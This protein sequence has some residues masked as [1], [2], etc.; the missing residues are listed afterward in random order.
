MKTI[1]KLKQKLKIKVSVNLAKK[2]EVKVE[3]FI[4]PIIDFA[5]FFLRSLACL[6]SPIISFRF[7]NFFLFFTVKHLRKIK[8]DIS[9]TE[10]ICNN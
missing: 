2:Y 8:I 6:N 9:F 3:N 7:F 10:I 5:A 4:N 1:D